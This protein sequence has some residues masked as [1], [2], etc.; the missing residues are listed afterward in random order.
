[1]KIGRSVVLFGGSEGGEEGT[2]KWHMHV[3]NVYGFEVCLFGE[4]VCL[5]GWCSLLFENWK[6]MESNRRIIRM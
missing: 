3:L 4:T 1:M 6:I 5:L 2:S